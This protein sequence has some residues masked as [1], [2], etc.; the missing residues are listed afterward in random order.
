MRAR[1]ASRKTMGKFIFF[2][3]QAYGQTDG[4]AMRTITKKCSK[5]NNIVMPQCSN[6][7]AAPNAA[8]QR[9]RSTPTDGKV[10]PTDGKGHRWK[11]SGRR[12]LAPG[13]CVRAGFHNPTDGKV[14]RHLR[15]PTDGKVHSTDGKV[16]RSRA[17]ASARRNPSRILPGMSLAPA[18]FILLSKSVRFL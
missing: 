7:D 18:R 9:R 14:H 10:H 8:L 13:D 5:T 3:W 11:S 16:H 15:Y 1:I 2:H 12:D 6:A 4:L 17:V